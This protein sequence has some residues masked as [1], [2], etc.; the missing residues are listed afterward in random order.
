M[1][2]IQPSPGEQGIRVTWEDKGPFECPFS[3]PQLYLLGTA[4]HSLGRPLA[5][6]GS[7]ELAV[8]PH[9]FLS[10]PKLHLSRAALETEKT[11]MLCKHNSAIATKLVHY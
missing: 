2:G 11:L 9:S 4:P 10:T 6:L 7:A 3:S 5:Q 8:A 1:A